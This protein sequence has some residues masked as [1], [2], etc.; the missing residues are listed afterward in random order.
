MREFIMSVRK[1]VE[2]IREK[3]CAVCNQAIKILIMILNMSAFRPYLSD[4][5]G[6][7]NIHF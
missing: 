2:C 6:D 5:N 3:I 4:S 7:M 1:T